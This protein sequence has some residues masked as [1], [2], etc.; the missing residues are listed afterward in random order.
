MAESI[1]VIWFIVTSPSL[2]AIGHDA[3]P[4]PDLWLTDALRQ[5]S[6]TAS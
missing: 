1:D 2:A 5:S 4:S 6:D 3:E